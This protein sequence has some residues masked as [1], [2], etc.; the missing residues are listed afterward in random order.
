M[1]VCDLF[2]K[3]IRALDEADGVFRRHLSL[4]RI[5]QKS[6]LFRDFEIVVWYYGRGT[7][8][9]CRLAVETWISYLFAL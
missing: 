5:C 8:G 4:P 3:F 1:V 7:A 2:V 9:L 6:I